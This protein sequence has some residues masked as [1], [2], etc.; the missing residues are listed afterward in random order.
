MKGAAKVH[1]SDVDGGTLISYEV[2]AQLGG[3]LA[4][5]GGPIIDA[6]A[7]QLAGKF[8]RRFAEIVAGAAAPGDAPASAVASA[9]ADATEAL[10]RT[11]DCPWHGYWRPSSPRSWDFFSVAARAARVPIGPELRSASC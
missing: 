6:T 2:Q 5:L 11:A 10:P 7:E 1:L 8:F 3:R 4:Q 9:P